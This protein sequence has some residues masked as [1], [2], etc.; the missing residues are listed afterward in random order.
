MESVGAVV[1]VSLVLVKLS[2]FNLYGNSCV[3]LLYFR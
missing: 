1:P 3:F 2:V